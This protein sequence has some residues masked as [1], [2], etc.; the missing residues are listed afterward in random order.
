M[1]TMSDFEIG[2]LYE[3]FEMQEYEARLA[4]EE[5]NNPINNYN[6]ETEN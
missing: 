5:E 2:Y 3:E 6:D 1:E 4:H